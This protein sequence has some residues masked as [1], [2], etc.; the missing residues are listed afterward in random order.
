MSD[1]QKA[2]SVGNWFLTILIS[3][4]PLVGLIMLFVWGFSSD[5]LTPKKNWARAMLIFYLIAAVFYFFLAVVIG[6]GSMLGN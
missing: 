2:M 4:I 5:T 3:G 6:I 1:Q